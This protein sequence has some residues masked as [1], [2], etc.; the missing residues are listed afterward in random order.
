MQVSGTTRVGDIL[1]G[2]EGFDHRRTAFR[3]DDAN[4]GDA[5]NQPHV[6]QFFESLINAQRSKSAADGLD[7]PIGGAPAE[8]FD[9]FVGDGFHRFARRNRT[10]AAI[11]QKLTA[12]GK[13]GG[14]L[15]GLIVV[16]ANADDFGAKQRLLRAVFLAAPGWS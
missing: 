10:C 15:L 9:N 14:D 8:L 13:L 16:A 3:L 6:E 11:K 1:A 7:V 12:L 2:F 4:F 5:V